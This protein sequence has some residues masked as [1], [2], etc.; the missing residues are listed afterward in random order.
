LKK[1]RVLTVSFSSEIKSYEIPA[2]RSA[3][4]EKAGRENTLFHNHLSGDAYLY[5]YPLIQYKTI[6]KKP[7]IMC[8]E[9]GVDEIHKFFEKRDWNIHI[10]DRLLEMKIH[11]L[12]LNQFTMQVWDKMFR[13][14]IRNWIALNQ[15]NVKRYE[16]LNGLVERTHF[17]EKTLTANIIS[18][19]KGIEWNIDKPIKLNIENI[20]SIKPVSMK[21]RKLMG[22]NLDFSTNVFLPNNIG[23]G[24]GVSL[25][26]G[27][28]SKQRSSKLNII[29][30]TI[31]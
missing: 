9:Y 11:N 6:Y 5:K 10:G 27:M 24:K 4:I 2:F 22:F 21:G 8:L 18:M 7:A 15:E 12:N 25:G 30:T 26:Y 14:G 23:L 1:I 31:I 20:N 28:V 17:L 29:K 13:Y 16:A 19:A 3:I